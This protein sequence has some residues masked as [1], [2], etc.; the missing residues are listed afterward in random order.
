MKVL[1]AFAMCVW[2]ILWVQVALDQSQVWIY[3]A[4][5]W[6]AI[7]VCWVCT[8][9]LM[10]WIKDQSYVGRRGRGTATCSS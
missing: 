5:F 1:T 8:V 10:K 7:A 2:L 9:G 4:V 6:T 3:F